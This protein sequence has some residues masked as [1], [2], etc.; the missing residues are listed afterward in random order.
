[1]WSARP[2]LLRDIAA[3]KAILE[4]TANPAVTVNPAQTCGSTS[5]TTIP[6][7][8]FGYGRVDALAAVNSVSSPTPTPTATS[9]STPTNTPTNTPT[10]TPTM[11]RTATP[12]T[13]A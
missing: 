3:T 5:S 12:F 4:N 11:T 8:S 6:N 9:T 13:V 1:L 2:Q 7:N 10:L